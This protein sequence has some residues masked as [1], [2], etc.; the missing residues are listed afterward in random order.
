M[1][2]TRTTENPDEAIREL[3]ADNRYGNDLCDKL[4]P[5]ISHD[6]WRDQ[7]RDSER[8]LRLAAERVIASFD[9][10]DGPLPII[11]DDS[12]AFGNAINRLRDALNESEAQS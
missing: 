8:R 10:E 1:S 7:P 3:H 5:R 12:L 9:W 4:H 2:D 6:Q 11:A